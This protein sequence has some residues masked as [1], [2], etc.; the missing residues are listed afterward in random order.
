MRHRTAIG[1]GA[2]LPSKAGSP[3]ATVRAAVEDLGAAGR[4]MA[5][6]SLYRTEPVGLTAQ[7]AFINAAAIVETS[8]DPEGLL[9]FLLAT[10]RSYGRD[11]ERD[12]PKGPRALDLDVLLIDE[13][14]IRTER[15]TVPHPALAERRFVL[16][17]LAEIAPR[18]QHPE[19][20]R[21]MAELLAA[22]PA[23]GANGPEAVHKLQEG[24]PIL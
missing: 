24:Q 20:G 4:V 9:E 6:S 13:E 22:L 12:V 19:L 7:P 15:L 1:V 5:R 3:E 2:N 8:L 14:I 10:E 18:W 11:R 16:A 17:P 21:T 23:E